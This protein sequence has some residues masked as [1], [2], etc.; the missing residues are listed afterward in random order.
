[1]IREQSLYGDARKW[2]QVLDSLATKAHELRDLDESELDRRMQGQL[3]AGKHAAALSAALSELV[4]Y[5]EPIVNAETWSQIAEALGAAIRRYSPAEQSSTSQ[6]GT[7]ASKFVDRMLTDSLPLVDALV[8]AQTPDYLQPSPT[9]LRAL[10][11]REL[12]R[13]S[14]LHGSAAI[15]V[16]VG[17]V[18]STRGL[19][20]D[21][22]IFVGTADG[23]LP[24][25][26]RTGA[27]L[28][29]ASREILRKSPADAPTV[30][31]LEDAERIDIMAVAEAASSLVV[32]FPRGAIPGTGVDQVARYFDPVN[33]ESRTSIASY[34]A[35]LRFGPKPVTDVDVVLRRQ[36]AGESGS[37][38]DETAV[39]VAHSWAKPHFDESFGNV[40]PASIDW[41][42]GA[43]AL[44]A[45]GIESFLRCPYH[46][47]VE[48]ILRFETD[49]YEDEVDQISSSDLGTMI[50]AAL[51]QLV[52]QASTEGWLPG[53]GEP[54]PSD[55]IQRAA[56]VFNREADSAERQGL[57]G[58]RPAWHEAR[59]EVV[60]ALPE[61]IAKD[62]ELRADPPM[63]PGLPEAP[64]GMHGHPAAEITLSSGTVVK[65]KGMIDRLDIST[66]G[67]VARVIDYKSGKKGNFTPGLKKKDADYHGRQKIQ[68]L[69]YS[70]AVQDL[71]PD[72][73]DV[74]VTFFFV[75]NQGDVQLVSPESTSDA[76][77]ELR[78]ILTH[79]EQ[80]L[81]S[82]EFPPN[83]RSTSDFCPVCSKLG[84]RALRATAA[85][86]DLDVVDLDLEEEFSG[87]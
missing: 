70:V 75:P 85:Y 3:R 64:F 56:E 48:R 5:L 18:S 10:L 46:F 1:M 27:L 86:R 19:T 84:R 50:H 17:P 16:N 61:F 30:V 24:S 73:V 6:A 72:V 57:T 15:G 62:N 28:T 69:V 60:A 49:T 83:M 59:E 39:R 21:R 42:L 58:W 8:E 81:D 11:D 23:L 35:G 53:P 67:Q 7:A 4:G 54:W 13:A 29:D 14:A 38:G 2:S 31:E 52:R 25:A 82:G 20:F 33:E 12:S 68:D 22:V 65:L 43:H 74:L 34:E 80:A 71:R 79:V 45:S 36:L 87:D 55:A 44:S 63:A 9:T 32:T 40:D 66:D 47:Y 78:E 77:Q 76:G 26:S 51:E 37:H 41:D